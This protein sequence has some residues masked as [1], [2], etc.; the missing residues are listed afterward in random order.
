LRLDCN[1]SLHAQCSDAL[2]YAAP[3]ACHPKNL[4]CL[5]EVHD[6]VNWQPRL[7]LGRRLHEL[8]KLRHSSSAIRLTHRRASQWAAI[9]LIIVGTAE[10]VG[11]AAWIAIQRLTGN[12]IGGYLGYAGQQSITAHMSFCYW[13]RRQ[14]QLGLVWLTWSSNAARVKLCSPCAGLVAIRNGIGLS[15]FIFVASFIA[16]IIKS[17]T[18]TRFGGVGAVCLH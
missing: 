5:L 16:G 9:T 11:A 7:Y 4:L 14:L 3:S 1:V 12:I 10:Y 15:F 2:R 8:L 13:Y 6:A 18:L 17:R